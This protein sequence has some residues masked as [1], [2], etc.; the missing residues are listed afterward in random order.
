MRQTTYL[1]GILTVNA[2]LLAGV[3]WTQLV[4][5]PVL[6]QSADAQTNAQG[7]PGIPN[8]G[9]QRDQM[10]R[11]LERL[12]VT[13]DSTMKHLQGGNLKTEVTNLKDIKIELPE[14]K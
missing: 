8:A 1:N 11:Q 3:L 9:G 7:L 4:N 12:N 2:V 13:L 6:A 10:I 5:R 14:S